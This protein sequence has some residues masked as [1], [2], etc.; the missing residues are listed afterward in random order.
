MVRNAGC[1]ASEERPP[2]EPRRVSPGA[3]LLTGGAV[4]AVTLDGERLA[5]EIRQQLRGRVDALRAAGV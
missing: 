1:P 5:G 2:G 4:S 3:L